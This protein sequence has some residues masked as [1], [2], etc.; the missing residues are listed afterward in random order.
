MKI[1]KYNEYRNISGIKL[2]ELG[3]SSKMS[4]KQVAERLQLEGI[5]LTEKEISKIE[6]NNLLVHDFELFAF[7]KIFKVSADYFNTELK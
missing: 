2:R 5:D 7:A 3:I 1:K 6:H 4:Q